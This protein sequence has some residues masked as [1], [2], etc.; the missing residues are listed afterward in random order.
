MTRE[1]AQALHRYLTGN[2]F[3]SGAL[4]GP[5]PGVRFNYRIWRFLKSALSFLPWRDEICYMQTQGYWILAN[6]LLSTGSQDPFAQIAFESCEHVM[7]SQRADGAW[8]FPNPEWRGRVTT[9]EGIWASLG[10]L[11]SHRRTGHAPFLE[12]VLKWDHFF[13]NRIGFQRAGDQCSVNYFAGEADAKVPNN[14]ALALRYLARLNAIKQQDGDRDRMR[15]L[16]RFLTQS[17]TENGEFPYEMANSR[18]QHFQCFQYQAF[19]LLDLLDYHSVTPDDAVKSIMHGIVKFLQQG[20]STEGDVAYQCGI[21]Y[22][23]VNYHSAVV[24]ASLRVYAQQCRDSISAT[25]FERL[26]GL[27]NRITSNLC[28]KQRANGSLPHSR[29]DYRVLADHRAYPRYL[30]MMLLHSLM[31]NEPSNPLEPIGTAIHPDQQLV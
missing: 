18:M 9:V 17:Q 2:H 16:I 10:L 5:D 8:E 30:A 15:G 26:L 27:C 25:D 23:T 22:R 29:G 31:S 19:I 12:T 6:W 3:R 21:E 11:E 13:K 24:A 28:S 7:K 14:S 1:F 4:I 20:I